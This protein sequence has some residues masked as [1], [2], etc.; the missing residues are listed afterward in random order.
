MIGQCDSHRLIRKVFLL[1]R[2]RFF[3][4]NL[5][6]KSTSMLRIPNE[7]VLISTGFKQTRTRGTDREHPMGQLHPPRQ[8]PSKREC[9]HPHGPS[10]SF[11]TPTHYFKWPMYHCGPPPRF[12]SQ[13]PHF[14]WPDNSLQSDRLLTS[15]RHTLTS[16]GHT[17]PA[18]SV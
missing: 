12:Y 2:R 8:T 16:T 13:T 1:R 11:F 3:S 17:Q 5:L 15:I 4:G 10:L 14:W 6:S 18:A 7:L 9:E